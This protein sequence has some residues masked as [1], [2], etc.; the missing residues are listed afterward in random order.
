MIKRKKEAVISI[1]D[2]GI[3]IDK[4]YFDKIFERFYRVDESRTKDTGGTGLGLSIV[5][6]IISIHSGSVEVKSEINK[7][8]EFI[9]HIPSKIH[10]EKS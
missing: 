3:G 7:G 1:K 8:S 9:L 2:E 6:K 5:K 4:K 10:K